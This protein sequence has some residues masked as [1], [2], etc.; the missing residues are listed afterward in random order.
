M[1]TCEGCK[2][3][4]WKKTEDGRLHPS[5]KGVCGYKYETA[6]I[7]ASMFWPHSETAPSPYG[8]Y[9]SC[10]EDLPRHCPCY[11]KEGEG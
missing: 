10:R 7:P 9:I 8:G 5:G 2:Y 6:A 1:K 3:A 4:E 11:E